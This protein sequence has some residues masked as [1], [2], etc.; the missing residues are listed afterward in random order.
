MGTLWQAA[1]STLLRLI[2]CF[3]KLGAW[4]AGSN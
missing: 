1:L 3:T 2:C 4:E